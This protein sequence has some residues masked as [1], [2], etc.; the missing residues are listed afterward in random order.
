MLPFYFVCCFRAFSSS[1]VLAD[2]NQPAADPAEQVAR[3]T[4][5]V[6]YNYI[7]IAYSR[8]AGRWASK[9]G[10]ASAM[11]RTVLP[12]SIKQMRDWLSR[13][14]IALGAPLCSAHMMM[15]AWRLFKDAW[16]HACPLKVDEWL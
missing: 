5:L 11:D 6:L 15:R 13:G 4:A 16:L 7:T 9:E 1:A 2:I 14:G 8:D 12:Y 3:A 10:V